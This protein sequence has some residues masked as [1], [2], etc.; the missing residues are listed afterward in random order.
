MDAVFR[1]V[2][3]ERGVLISRLFNTAGTVNLPITMYFFFG[4]GATHCIEWLRTLLY[5]FS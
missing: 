3:D 1:S 2:E 5:L 4:G